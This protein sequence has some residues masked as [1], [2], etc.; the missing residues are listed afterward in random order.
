MKLK[1]CSIL[2]ALVFILAACAGQPAAPATTPG[3]ANSAVATFKTPIGDLE[4]VSAR[5]VEDANGVKPTE[6][7]KLLLVV[8]KNPDNSPIDL[9]KFVD[10]QMNIIIR[11][12][13]G[14][15]TIHTMG[16]FVGEQFAIG[17]QVPETVKT[18]TLVWGD[19]APFTLVPGE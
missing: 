3:A 9:Q 8:V 4:F 5:F 18:Y 19:N 6:G 7:F 17:F 16:G 2:L 13:D 14:S 12:D 11:G 10:A 15:E 1:Q